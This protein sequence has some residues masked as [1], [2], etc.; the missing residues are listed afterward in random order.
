MSPLLLVRLAVRG[1][2]NRAYWRRWPERIGFTSGPTAP[3]LAW[4][5]AVSVGEV[6]AAAPLVQAIVEQYPGQRLVVTT[7]TPTGSDQARRMFGDAVDHAYIPYDF[8]G[9]VSRFLARVRPE[10]AVIM[11]TEIWPN[12]LRGCQARRIPVTFAN[13]RLSQKSFD[14]Y[15]RVRAL[16][17][18]PL[19]SAAAFAVQSEADAARLRALGARKGTVHIT[20]SIK[21]EVPLPARLT[22]LARHLR[23]HWGSDREIVVAG[24]THEG[25]EQVILDAYDA[26]KRDH[27]TL[28]MV[29]VPRHPERFDQVARLVRRAGYRFARRSESAASLPAELEIYVGDTMG[30]LPTFYAA[31]DVAIVG[32]SFVP[33]GGHNILEASAVGIPVIFG[34]HMFNFDDISRTTLARGAGLQ[35]QRPEELGALLAEYLGQPRKRAQAGRAGARMVEENRG[36]LAHTLGILQP[37]LKKAARRVQAAA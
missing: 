24:S 5:H 35:A 10:L 18:G 36:A 34:P 22:E 4:V 33:V 16:F 13:V 23:S 26:V 25:E 12:V 2:G 1:F 31:A 17:R 32:G 8:P 6:N 11:E 28:L 21:F 9:A 37:H 14:G 29:L 30:E 27:P 7:M 3:H 15:R 20:G 19:Q